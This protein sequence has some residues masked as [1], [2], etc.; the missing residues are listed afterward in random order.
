VKFGE[1]DH[2]AVRLLAQKTSLTP[3]AGAGEEA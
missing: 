2:F 1:L 3:D